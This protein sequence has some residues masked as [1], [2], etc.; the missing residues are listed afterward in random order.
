M[1]YVDKV[2]AAFGFGQIFREVVTTLHRGATATFILHQLS[3]EV[4]VE[5]SIRQ[6]D[7]L[8]LLLFIIKQEP[9]LWRLE[10]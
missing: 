6:G 1:A 3:P 10:H 2:L 5:F 7:P 4:Q 8:A 9:Y